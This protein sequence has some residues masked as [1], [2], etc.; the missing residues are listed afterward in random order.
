ME[1]HRLELDARQSGNVLAELLGHNIL[2]FVHLRI[3]VTLIAG[4]VDMEGHDGCNVVRIPR[5]VV[6][7]GEIAP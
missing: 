2:A 5:R 3:A 7:L 6:T 1:R 4:V